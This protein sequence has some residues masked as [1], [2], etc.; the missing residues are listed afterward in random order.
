M[1]LKAH[2]IRRQNVVYDYFCET[3]LFS[4]TYVYAE[5]TLPEEEYAKEK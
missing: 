4:G 5:W 1:L 3:S 2:F